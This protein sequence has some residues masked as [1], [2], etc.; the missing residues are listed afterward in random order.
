MPLAE[1]LTGLQDSVIE[2]GKFTALG[3]SKILERGTKLH[4]K[5]GQFSAV[6]D[7]RAQG[8]EGSDSEG[9]TMPFNSFLLLTT[10]A[11]LFQIRDREF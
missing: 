10:D 3:N 6:S 2:D 1:I 5:G 8:L 9:M 4:V 11:H 7:E